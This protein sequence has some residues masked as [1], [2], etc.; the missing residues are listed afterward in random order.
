MVDE[1]IN[2]RKS[3]KAWFLLSP[4]LII[5]ILFN[6]L[7]LARTVFL[8]FQSSSLNNSHFIGLENYITVLT[9]SR[10]HQAIYNT[11]IYALA[12]VPIGLI[13]SLIIAA[14]LYDFKKFQ[15]VFEV[16]FFMPY[17]ISTVAKG[18]IFRLLLNEDYGIINNILG[19][20]NIMP[21]NFLDDPEIALLTIIIFGIWSSLGF[22][23]VILLSG[24]RNLNSQYYKMASVCGANKFQQFW[25]ITLP[26]LLPIITFLLTVNCINSFRIYT[27]VYT[28]FNGKAGIGYS[29]ITAVYYIYDKFYVVN[30]YGEGMAAAVIL[31]MLILIFTII[32]NLILRK[33]TRR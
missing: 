25:L 21:I 29:A 7:P 30:R 5:I 27:E 16:I 3:L 15:V 32:Q 10:F 13:I 14:I 28:I 19:W 20:F 18:S 11:A 22:N 9:D 17:I 31:F 6:L 26:Q 23:I 4:A 33:L 2:M 12:V 24:L 8:S 1:C